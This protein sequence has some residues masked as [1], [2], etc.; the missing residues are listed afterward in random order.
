LAS[1]G[2]SLEAN[3]LPG[4]YTVP[5]CKE[6]NG[7]RAASTSARTARPMRA[8]PHGCVVNGETWLTTVSSKS[9][10]PLTEKSRAP[11]GSAGSTDRVA[12]TR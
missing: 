2:K 12:A 10:V 7:T 9:S 1:R 3:A 6:A 5:R 4:P 11:R 8:K